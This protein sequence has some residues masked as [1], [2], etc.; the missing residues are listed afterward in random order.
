M[1]LT[2]ALARRAAN[3]VL[4]PLA[5]LLAACA[6]VDPAQRLRQ[7]DSLAAA[8]GWQRHKLQAGN[9]TLAAYH[10]AA[11]PRAATLTVYLE[12]DGLAWLSAGAVS[13]DP[14]PMHP[15]ALRL[16][17]RHPHGAVAYLA[18]PCQFQGPVLPDACRSALW[19]DARYGPEVVDSMNAAIDQLVQ[20]S[21]ARRLVLVGYSGGGAVAALL[22]A[23]RTDVALLLTVAA[24]L[25]TVEWAR[26][27]RL[28]PLAA[29]FNPA[30]HAAALARV[31]QQHWVG[32]ADD[33]VPPAV[34]AAYAARFPAGARPQVTVVPGFGH[35]CCWQDRWAQMVAP[36]LPP[37]D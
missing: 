15:V 16:A 14:T 35:A 8:S 31:P 13:P 11:A 18:R 26:L 12:G 9:F 1:P 32:A 19:T 6:G 20:R 29:S 37:A 30:D 23:R 21:G 36:F 7:A 34:L 24:N 5:G 4:L 17:L 2:Q 28:S 22:A 25:D 10:P 3:L 27:Q 33:V